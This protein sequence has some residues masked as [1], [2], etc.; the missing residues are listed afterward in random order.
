LGLFRLVTYIIHLCF[1][2]AMCIM[3]CMWGGT[4]EVLNLQQTLVVA[5]VS[6]LIVASAYQVRGIVKRSKWAVI[7]PWTIWTVVNA[8]SFAAQLYAGSS[9]WELMIPLSQLASTFVMLLVSASVIVWRR[10]WRAVGRK[11]WQNIWR[12][13]WWKLPIRRED[14]I[15]LLCCAVG[16]SAG[17]ITKEPLVAL[18]GNGLA[19]FAGLV[20]MVKDAKMHPGEVTRPYWTFR[21]LSVVLATAVFTVRGFNIAGLIPQTVG[22]IIVGSVV[23]FGILQ[24]KRRSRVLRTSRNPDPMLSVGTLKTP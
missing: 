15:A 3:F 2:P 23:H 19:N 9:W 22:M 10:G 8:V 14:A 21:G 5:S 7:V 13:D 12:K 6:A 20:P 16:V 11:M 17:I 1:T 24:P 4:V 18:V